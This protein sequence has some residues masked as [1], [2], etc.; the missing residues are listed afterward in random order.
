M[1]GYYQ[2][3]QGYSS[4][5]RYPNPPYMPS[6]NQMMGQPSGYPN[7][8]AQQAPPRKKSGAKISQGKNGKPVMTGWK[9]SRN[10]FLTLVACPNNGANIARKDGS[11]ITNAKGQE[12]ARW[13]CTLVDR[14]TG[15][16]TTHSGLYNL[17]TGKLY[18]PDL[19]MVASPSAPNGGYFGNSYV[20]KRR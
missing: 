12:Y 6:I 7:G 17:T 3:Q 4:Q 19:K 10:A 15:S 9:K 2:Q 11:I 16:V 5:R 1:A 8:Y 14:S 18:I 13:T 20:S